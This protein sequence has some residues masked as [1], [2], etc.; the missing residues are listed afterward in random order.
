[1]NDD[2][3]AP[4]TREPD[5]LGAPAA[6]VGSPLPATGERA[7]AGA[8]AA[9]LAGVPRVWWVALAVLGLVGLAAIA[10]AWKAE[11]QVAGLEQ[12]LVRRQ[13]LSASSADDARL[14]AKR[15]QESVGETAAK[16]ALLDA[17]VAEVAVQRTQLDELIHSLSRSRDENLLVD[18]EASIRAALQQS[19]LTG[20]AEPLVATLRQSDERLAR[21]N[22]PRLEGVRRAIAR[23]LER[24]KAVTV[25]DASALGAKL[26]EAIRL[27]D[28]LPLLAG[29]EARRAS[30]A[31]S[32]GAAGTTPTL[33]PD[34]AASAVPPSGWASGLGRAWSTVTERV[35]GEAKALV[36]VTHIERPEAM[37]IAPQQSVFLRENLKLR[38]LN[39]RLALLSRQYDTAQ[40][41]LHVV[42]DALGRYFDRSAR[43]TVLATELVRDVAAQ[44]RQASVPRPDDTLAALIA[45]SAGR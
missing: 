38:L 4:A 18:V 2:L 19:A 26:D 28:D 1:M 11:R 15:A 12:E 30:L 21:Y 31:E 41:D 33:A 45:A 25:A 13:Q 14:L 6:P 44:P 22:Q 35:W 8:N 23:D 7:A 39:A 3:N 24:V 36:R 29:A 16:V 40:A 17:R 34:A 20:S 37:L 5:G 43:R 32:A 27:I 9:L 42:Q 10:L